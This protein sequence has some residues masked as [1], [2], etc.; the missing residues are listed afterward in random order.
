MLIFIHR[1]AEEGEYLEG[2]ERYEGYALDL[3]DGIAKMHKFQYIF[4]IEKEYGSYNKKTK[5]WNGLVKR[6]IDRV[7]D[8]CFFF[9]LSIFDTFACKP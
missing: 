2:N 5:K 1:K 6:L 8:N 4:E 3:I 9:L 7:G